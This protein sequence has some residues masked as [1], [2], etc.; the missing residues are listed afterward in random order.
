MRSLKAFAVSLS[1]GCFAVFLGAGITDANAKT[2]RYGSF[3]YHSKKQDTL[4]L[5]GPITLKAAGDLKK[6]LWHHPRVRVL[7]LNSGGGKIQ[8]G[9]EAA[10]VIYDRQ[11][12]TIVSKKGQCYSSCAFLYFAGQKRTVKGRLG[13]HQ[14]SGN[15]GPVQLGSAQSLISHV[16]A[17]MNKFDADPR[18]TEIMLRTPHQNMHVFSKNEIARFGINE[19]PKRQVRNSRYKLIAPQPAT[20]DGD[21]GVRIWSPGR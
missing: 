10:D 18:V 17:A 12:E 3:V 13:V 21:T 7:Y 9:L 2:K 1:V 6:A 4:F 8:G 15:E 20:E 5:N 14:M 11:I 16:V 19:R